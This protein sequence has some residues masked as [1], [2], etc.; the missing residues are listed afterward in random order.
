MLSG[1]FGVI[2]RST[3]STAAKLPHEHYALSLACPSDTT[4]NLASN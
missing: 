3:L 2:K 4:Q 1:A